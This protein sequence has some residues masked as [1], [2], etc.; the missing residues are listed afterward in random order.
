M[1]LGRVTLSK[2]KSKRD[3]GLACL[4]IVEKKFYFKAHTTLTVT[5]YQRL[6]EVMRKNEGREGVRVITTLG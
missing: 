1:K 6:R 2:H 3:F 5:F 4:G